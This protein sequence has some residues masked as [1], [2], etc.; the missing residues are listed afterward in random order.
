[1]YLGAMV[2]VAS[3]DALYKNPMHP[4][5]QALM[6]AI[7]ILDPRARRKRT[8]L[9]GSIPS[10]INPPPGCKFH[11]RCPRCMDRCKTEAPKQTVISD[12]QFVYC[13]LYD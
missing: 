5:T 10:A 13:H 12:E 2:E 6:A 3:K 9:E 1:M 8:I 7:P 11:T 4:Y